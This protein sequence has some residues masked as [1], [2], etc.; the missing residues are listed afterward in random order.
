ML[1]MDLTLNWRGPIGAGNFP[2]KTDLIGEL[3]EKKQFGTIPQ[4]FT[5]KKKSFPGIRYLMKFR[6]T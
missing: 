2:I 5:D 4:K 1:F 6:T 3:K